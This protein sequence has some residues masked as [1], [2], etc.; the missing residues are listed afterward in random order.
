MILTLLIFIVVLGVLVFVHELGHFIVA[1]RSGMKVEEFGFGF[2]PRLA[3]IQKL[4][5]RWKFV[6]GKAK[7]FDGTNTIYSINWIPLGGF[8]RIVGENNED[9]GDPQSFVNK[10]FFPR[11]LTLLAGVLMNVILAWL[12]FSAGYMSGLPVGLDAETQLPQG[13]RLTERHVL[14]SA[15][16]PG[17]PAEQAGIKAND[18]VQSVD[19]QSFESTDQIQ[20]YIVSRK[21]STFNFELRRINEEIKVEVVSLATPAEGEGPVGIGLATYGKLH[22]PWY[23]SLWE[24]AKTTAYGLRDIVTGLYSVFSSGVGLK[25]LGG[26]VKIAQLTGQVADLGFVHLMQFTAFLSLNLAILNA[27]PFPALDGGRI[28]FLIIEKIRGKRNNQ[29]IEQ[30]AN[31]VGFL[32]L[33]LLMVAV[34]ARDLTGV[35]FLRNLF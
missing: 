35:Q 16:R 15:I 3:G 20:N 21:G 32:L 33:L 5:G 13:A 19:G 2:P 24:G 30:I 12:L 22:F 26:P 8:V 17:S 6:W 10:P 25:S 7:P 11:L 14:I 28:L 1:K 29:K 9:E 34:T 4:N 27:L 31:T 18:V 23:Q